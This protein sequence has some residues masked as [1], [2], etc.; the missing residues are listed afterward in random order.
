VL[1]ERM[2]ERASYALAQRTLAARLAIPFGNPARSP[3]MRMAAYVFGTLS[4]VIQPYPH[5]VGGTPMPQITDLVETSTTNRPLTA[6][7][8]AA[9]RGQGTVWAI[10][11]GRGNVVWDGCTRRPTETQQLFQRGKPVDF[12]LADFATLYARH[13]DAV[14]V[15]PPP[16]WG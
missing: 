5:R 8:V 4:D 6:D 12:S 2:Q 1:H 15:V 3:E 16:L 10:Y 11:Q 13:G 14:M 7:E 9:R